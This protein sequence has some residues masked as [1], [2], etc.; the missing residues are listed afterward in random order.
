M[1]KKIQIQKDSLCEPAVD[2]VKG[3]LTMLKKVKRDLVLMLL[4]FKKLTV[5]SYIT[6]NHRN[7]TNFIYNS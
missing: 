5:N 7:N 3:I 2:S 1:S 6:F 4:V